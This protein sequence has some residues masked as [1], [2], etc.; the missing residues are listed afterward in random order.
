MR[1]THTGIIRGC[2]ARTPKDWRRTRRFRETKMYWIDEH[3]TKYSKK[4]RGQTTG[5]WPMYKLDMESLTPMEERDRS[6]N[7][8]P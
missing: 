1:F 8:G 3:G 5:D 6:A 2:D 7:D 4:W